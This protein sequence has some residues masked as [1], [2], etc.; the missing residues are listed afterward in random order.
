M[1]R[2]TRWSCRLR[3]LVRGLRRTPA[4]PSSGSASSASGGSPLRPN[5]ARRDRS[6]ER[7]SSGVG[8][9]SRIVGI[10]SGGSRY[11]GCSPWG[12]VSCMLSLT[13]LWRWCGAGPQWVPETSS[14]DD[15]WNKVRSCDSADVRGTDGGSFPFAPYSHRSLTVSRSRGRAQDLSKPQENH[16]SR[17]ARLALRRRLCV[18]LCLIL[19]AACGDDGTGPGLRPSVAITPDQPVALY[20]G[21]PLTVRATIRNM[22]HTGVTYR[23]SDPEVVDIDTETGFAT[24]RSPG[25]ARLAG[26]S[27]IDP[28]VFAEIEVTVLPDLPASLTLTE[29]TT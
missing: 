14:A 19:L 18:A 16:S 2:D 27:A 24:A 11:P 9:A 28:R 15:A 20:V 29:L 10:G 3:M 23:S 13:N 4:S 7:V 17:P 22:S 5:Q 25:S 12:A 8:G 1:E 26:I 21:D 6:G